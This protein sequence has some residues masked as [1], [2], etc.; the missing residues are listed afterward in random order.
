MEASVVGVLDFH[1]KPEVQW[2]QRLASLEIVPSGTSHPSI[3][4]S[5]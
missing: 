5:R 3:A 2:L 4:L 1:A